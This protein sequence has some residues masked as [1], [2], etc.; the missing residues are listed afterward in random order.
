MFVETLKASI[1]V[2]SLTSLLIGALI[3]LFIK[4]VIEDQVPSDQY[5]VFSR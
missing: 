2:K 5:P 3:A 1:L 4:K